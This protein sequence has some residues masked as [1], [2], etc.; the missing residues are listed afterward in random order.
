MADLPNRQKR[1]QKTVVAAISLAI[2]AVSL[3]GCVVVPAGPRRVAYV[4][5]AP[6]VVVHPVRARV[7]VW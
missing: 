2:L 1:S 6:V 5:P 7:V 3:A 4:A